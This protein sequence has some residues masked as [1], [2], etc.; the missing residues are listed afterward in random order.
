M[1]G[2]IAYVSADKGM[3]VHLKDINQQ[4]LDLGLEEANKLLAK[5]VTKKRKTP[6][7][8]GQVLNR[9]QPTL[10]DISLAEENFCGIHFFNPVHRMPLVEVIKGEKTSDET[11]NKAV[12]YVKQLGKTPIVIN[13]C[14]GFLVNRCLTP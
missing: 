9:I 11:I 12:Q 7:A 6:L 10:H 13:D 3:H 8:M 1:G 5:Q 2:G 14:A 4:G